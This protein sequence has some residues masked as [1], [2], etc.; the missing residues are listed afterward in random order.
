METTNRGYI[1]LLQL[2]DE[3]KKIVYKIGKT[4][5]INKR[6]KAYNLKKILFSILINDYEEKEKYLITLIKNKYSIASGREF[7]YPNEDEE[8]EELKNFFMNIIMNN[9]NNK[10]DTIILDHKLY[11]YKKD[12][13][14]KLLK[15]Y[16]EKIESLHKINDDKYNSMVDEMNNKIEYLENLNNNKY[17]LLIELNEKNNELS[18]LNN[19]LNTNKY[20]LTDEL[21]EKNTLLSSLNNK[22]SLLNVELNNLKDKNLELSSLNKDLN[23]KHSELSSLNKDLNKKLSL[24]NI[25][26]NNL[27]DKNLQLSSLNIE[28]N[29]KNSELLSLNK[30][31]NN[32][33]NEKNNISSLN[34]KTNDGILIKDFKNKYNNIEE[35]KKEEEDDI[36][37]YKCNFCNFSSGSYSDIKR[38]FNK[39]YLC[40]DINNEY[41]KYTI[42]QRIILSLLPDNTQYNYIDKL[43]DDYKNIYKN[44]IKELIDKLSF[45]DGNKKCCSYCNASFDKMQELREHI[46]IDC[47]YNETIN[48]IDNDNDVIYKCKIC[49]YSTGL[50]KDMRRHF[51]K[52]Y[53]CK[54]VN[55]EYCK[56]TKDQQIILSLL[57]ENTSDKNKYYIDKLKPDYK[58]IYKNNIKELTDKLSLKDG[59]KKC[60]SYCNASFDKIQELREHI[61]IDCFYNEIINKC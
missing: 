5:Q 47:F 18:L 59:N 35:E 17:N 10:I 29:K 53:L 46:L 27:R 32:K 13:D 14:E 49:D 41:S 28:L 26:L 50:F 38:H 11:N 19:Q 4:D 54:Y 3:K 30:D 52:K 20:N 9:N 23:K 22:L 7:F 57:P 42:D 37:I 60:C 8:E 56:Y 40:K 31:L 6:L 48:N 45:K 15:D 34:N 33:V 51:N 2:C 16:S 58:N 36:L 61:L 12:I 1:Y 24:L 43:K 44:N 55:N 21:D 39:K 25:E